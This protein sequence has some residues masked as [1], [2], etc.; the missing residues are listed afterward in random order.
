MT[1]DIVTLTHETCPYCDR[2]SGR[3]TSQPFRKS[4][5]IKFKGTLI[6]PKPLITVLSE[7]SGIEEFQIVFTTL[8]PSDPFSPEHLQV[9]IATEEDK[10][11]IREQVVQIVVQAFEMRPE[12]IF[13]KKDEIYD[14]DK[15]FKS[16]R[17]IRPPRREEH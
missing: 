2:T 12:V 9:R 5:L 16:K 15:G 4:D 14:P 6:N 3:I 1:G 10:D 17:V 7:L 8:H 11:K 13:V